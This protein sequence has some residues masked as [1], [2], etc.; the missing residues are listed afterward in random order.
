VD[1]GPFGF[2]CIDPRFGIIDESKCEVENRE[3]IGDG[4]C[5]AEGGYN[6]EECGWDMG[7]CCEEDCNAEYSFYPC[8]ANQPFSCDNPHPGKGKD[9]TQTGPSGSAIFQ[10]TSSPDYF[11]DGF[12]A[13][14]FDPLRWRWMDGQGVWEIEHEDD[15]APAF[16]GLYYAEALTEDIIDDLDTAE[17]EL[18]VNSPNGGTLSYAIQALIQAPYE[19]VLIEVDGVA[20]YILMDAIPMWQ[21][22]TLDI[23]AGEHKIKWV[24]RKNPSDASDEDL[25]M[26]T[27]N[28]GITRVDDVMFV[29]N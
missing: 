24:V 27:P 26:S 9:V 11:H 5:D 12:E 14:V 29:P 22:Q 18:K 15:E 16:E 7:D 19:D 2:F 20:Q 8:G 3:W 13:N 25:A 28:L 4:G 21:T 17:L 1:Y 23:D 6:T 10:D